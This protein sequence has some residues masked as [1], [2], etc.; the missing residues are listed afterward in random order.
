MP[1]R[2]SRDDEVNSI[3]AGRLLPTDQRSFRNDARRFS[4]PGGA[5]RCRLVREIPD[6]LAAGERIRVSA[7][8]PRICCHAFQP[9][10]DPRTARTSGERRAETG[11]SHDWSQGGGSFGAEGGCLLREGSPPD[12]KGGHTT[13]KRKP[14]DR[15]T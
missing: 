10:S 4:P 7:H 3:L 5:D 13:R 8:E 2:L 12:R 6:A 9:E 11:H 14:S 1:D 15:L